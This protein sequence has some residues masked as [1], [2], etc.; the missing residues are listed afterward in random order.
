MPAM[1]HS[2]PQWFVAVG[3]SGSQGFQDID[4]LLGVLPLLPNATVLVVLHRRSNQVSILA[5]ILGRHARM[6]V[7]VAVDGK[8]FE[9]GVCYVGEPGDHLALVARSIGKLVADQFEGQHRNRTVDLL[10]SS[11][12]RHAEGWAIGVVLSGALD[13]G[14]SGLAAIHKAGGLTMVLSPTNSAETGGMPR[15]AIDYDGPID[16]TGSITEIA[17]AIVRIVSSPKIEKAAAA[18]DQS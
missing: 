11:V 1:L 2:S 16:V 13:D 3:A 18:E 7:V 10:F 5:Q 6:P 8:R 12:A 14:S 17:D 15:N 4:R 9:R